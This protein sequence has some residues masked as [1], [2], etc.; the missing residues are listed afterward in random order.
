M[1][2]SLRYI[3]PGI[4]AHGSNWCMGPL[5]RLARLAQFRQRDDSTRLLLR[6]NCESGRR[7]PALPRRWPRRGPIPVSGRIRQP[8]KAGDRGL[9]PGRPTRVSSP[10]WPARP[11]EPLDRGLAR[12]PMQ[13]PSQ[14]RGV[15]YATHSCSMSGVSPSQRFA[16]ALTNCH[17][18]VQ[19]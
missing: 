5:P 10:A 1:A 12:R 18:P 6:S 2:G 19:T 8:A 3:V 7:A 16:L 9:P 4:G 13:L 11:I 15:W 17:F 14:S